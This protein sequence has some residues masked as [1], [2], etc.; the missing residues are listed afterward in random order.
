MRQSFAPENFSSGASMKRKF[1]CLLAAA[2]LLVAQVPAAFAQTTNSSWSTV[3]SVPVDERLIVRQKDG[4]TIEGK[5]IEANENNLSLS[6]SGKV[7]NIARD[8]IQQIQHVKGKAAKGKWT[9][10]GTGIGAAVGGGIGATRV[11]A[12][13]DDSEIWVPVGII[14]GAGAGAVG[15]LIFGATRRNRT[16]IYTAP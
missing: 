1:F 3:Q 7:V 6:R 12:D 9:L 14:F 2:A 10:I 11:S 4:K 16:I 13:H 5:M 8:S 15:G